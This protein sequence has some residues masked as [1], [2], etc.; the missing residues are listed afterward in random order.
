MVSPGTVLRCAGRALDLSTPLV[1][2]ILNVTPDSF[3]DGG[4]FT[5]P[6]RAVE[7]ALRM[8]EEG[9][10]IIDVGGESTRPG[11]SAVSESEE[12]DR[13]LPV[14]ERLARYTAAVISVDTSKPQVMRAAAAAGA[15]L[16]NDVRALTV[17]GALAAAAASSCAVCLMHM[18]GEPATMQRD[19]VYADVVSEVKAFLLERVQACRTAGVPDER[20]AIDPGFGFGKTL[21]HNLELLQR[22]PELAESG[23]P[24][25]VGFSRKSMAAALTGRASDKRA[26]DR[27]ASGERLPASLAL[28]TIAVL[29]GACIVRAHD[30]APTLDAV[31]V[32]LAVRVRR[33]SE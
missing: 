12:L 29:H 11:A 13:V 17:P 27:R 8:V 25:L 2:G 4:R 22:L 14:I 26:S 3:S 23:V 33:K 15:G 6:D 9:A 30:V 31:R 18:Q 24:V 28:A 16:I 20:I 32:A 19:P 21:A 7:H 5:D 10:A 1:M